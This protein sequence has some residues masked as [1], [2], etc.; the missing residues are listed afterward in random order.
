MSFSTGSFSAEIR[1]EP[2]PWAVSA[3]VT[4]QFPRSHVKQLQE[5]GQGLDDEAP[6]ELKKVG[7]WTSVSSKNRKI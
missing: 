6:A 4:C 7:V 2:F 1:D 5:D 3:D